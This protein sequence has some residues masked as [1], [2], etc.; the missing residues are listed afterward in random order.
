LTL[1]DYSSEGSTLRVITRHLTALA[2]FSTLGILAFRSLLFSGGVVRYRDLLWP[3]DVRELYLLLAYIWPSLDM[4]KRSV[5][6]LPLTW[7][8]L[9]LGM[10]SGLLEGLLLVSAEVLICFSAY[11]TVLKLVFDHKGGIREFI[12]AL[13]CGIVYA[14]NPF[15]LQHVATTL[16]FSLA[17][18]FFPFAFLFFHRA[19]EESKLRDCLL[20]ALFL[21]LAVSSCVHYILLSALVMGPWF[22]FKVIEELIRHRW[23]ACIKKIFTL[24]IILC[25]FALFSAHWLLP[26]L[27]YLYEGVRLM[28][29]YVLNL[30]MLRVFSAPAK[31]V[32]VLRFTGV[33]WPRVPLERPEWLPEF[34]WLALS[35]TLPVYV[36]LAIPVCKDEDKGRREVAYF[37]FISVMLI[38]LRKGAREPLSW[39]YPELYKLPIVGWMFR[40]PTKFGMPLAFT[41]TMLLALGL[42]EA[43]KRL[44]NR[45]FTFVV[46][47]LLISVCLMAW[48]AYTGDF[49][50]VFVPSLLSERELELWRRIRYSDGMLLE[51]TDETPFLPMSM[52]SL[53]ASGRVR[54][55]GDILSLGGVQYLFVKND[56][57]LS[58]VLVERRDLGYLGNIDVWDVFENGHEAREVYGT[59]SLMLVLG[60]ID[61]LLTL[62]NM[63]VHVG[64][65]A[66]VFLQHEVDSIGPEELFKIANTSI[67]VVS[68]IHNATDF[69]P[70]L[71]KE[72]Y[73]VKPFEYTY[74]HRPDLDWSR[75]GATDPLYGPWHEYLNERG[76]DNWDLDY[77][78]GMVFTW[79]S[80]ARLTMRFYVKKGTYILLMRYFKNREGGRIKVV[81]D[82]REATQVRTKGQLDVFTWIEVYKGELE[83]GAHE[84]TIENIEGFNAVNL[85]LV[86]P[87]EE[88]YG[89]TLRR[90]FPGANFV[91]LLEGERDFVFSGGRRVFGV[92][93][94]CGGGY[95]SLKAGGRGE[96]RVFVFK[97]GWYSILMRGLGKFKIF[98]NGVVLE[99]RM[100]SFK[101]LKLGSVRLDSG[102]TRIALKCESE[103][104]I[105]DALMLFSEGVN[106][107]SEHEVKV[108]YERVSPVEYM[109]RLNGSD[110]RTLVLCEKYDPLWKAYAGDKELPHYPANLMCNA[111]L[112]PRGAREVRIVYV[113]QAAFR[114]GYYIAVAAM[115]CGVIYVLYEGVRGRKDL[116]K[117]F[118]QLNNTPLNV[119]I[120]ACCGA[121]TWS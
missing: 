5:L 63:G 68:G 108:V 54:D 70:L 76:I 114:Y 11:Y 110:I 53:S 41:S 23:R 31:L 62:S 4:S 73:V 72:G 27:L 106:F 112:V 65:K 99:V 91:Y 34:I 42:R 49:G 18:G 43:A 61:A 75:A 8:A 48:P 81:L 56:S 71:I 105:L 89:R 32:N 17:Y 119:S 3:Y 13:I 55:L 87:I 85:I 39:I 96:G 35:L 117:G 46:G 58:H 79:A 33:W 52:L 57:E 74:E 6:L 98:I 19:V 66:W 30:E 7:L 109:V 26:S 1:C 88:Y 64:G 40:V 92:P 50:G 83:G 77:G 28:P 86:I 44:D 107:P 82:G 24:I 80:K 113:G 69:L 116:K 60:G 47:Y 78:M 38:F 37:A 111:Y 94:A 51:V 90:S 14:F 103:D 67:L 20:S 2:I 16:F 93:Y 12:I 100:D 22:L 97:D 121:K 21:A 36:W 120:K 101:A 25:F 115:A 15:T 118:K 45:T 29:N 104:G 9:K 102:V 95:L 84:I 10:T 59:R